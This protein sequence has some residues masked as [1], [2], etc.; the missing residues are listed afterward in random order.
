MNEK[1]QNSSWRMDEEPLAIDGV[2]YYQWREMSP[3][4]REEHGL[5]LVKF[6]TDARKH[7]VLPKYEH[8][9]RQ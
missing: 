8:E 6:F 9:R 7:P 5:H 3:A 2:P 1:E 4:W